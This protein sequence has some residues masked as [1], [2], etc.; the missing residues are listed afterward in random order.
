MKRISTLFSLLVLLAMLAQAQVAVVYDPEGNITHKFTSSEVSKIVWVDAIHPENVSLDV[1]EKQVLHRSTFSLTATVTPALAEDKSLSWST[2]DA[3]VATVTDAGLVTCVGVGSATITV[4]TVDGHKTAT[5]SVTVN[6][7]L[8]TGVRLNKTKMLLHISNSE[9]L[10]ATITPE[11]ASDKSVTWSSDNPSVATVDANGRVSAVAE[12]LASIMVATADEKFVDYCI[13]T[14]SQHDYVDL[15]LSVMWAPYNIGATCPEEYGDCYAWGETATKS[16][17]SWSNY[18]WC[19]GTSS[20]MTKYCTNSGDGTVDEKNVLEPEDDIAT[21]LWG[22]SWRMPSLA[23]LDE[24]YTRCTW[25]WTDNYNSTGVAGYIVKSNVTGY[26]D[27]TIFLPAAG[28]YDT[29]RYD[30]GIYGGYWSGSLTDGQS[31]C[32]DYMLFSSDKVAT[33][34]IYRY[35]GLSARPVYDDRIYVTGIELGETELAW[36]VGDAE[37]LDVTISPA[38]AT[39]K[40]VTWT[41]SKP[42]VLSVDD[43][44][45]ITALAVGSATITATTV[46][47]GYEASCTIT[48][49]PYHEYV[50]LGLSVKWATFN[51]GATSQDMYGDY[52]AWG[53]TDERDNYSYE[54]YSWFNGSTYDINKYCTNENR[55]TVDG[56]TTLEPDDDVAHVLWGGQWRMPTEAE[57]KELY[58]NCDRWPYKDYNGTGVAGHLFTSRKEGYTAKSVFLPAGSVKVDAKDVELDGWGFYWSS[59]LSQVSSDQAGC[60]VLYNNYD[61]SLMS[62]MRSDGCTIRPVRP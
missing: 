8:V 14:V 21:V 50:D 58:E 36:S 30:N 7:V 19:N 4:A 25:T 40:E 35:W 59:T 39:R 49:S 27:G 20:S 28:Y 6:P 23:E 52:Y 43:S 57:F 47:G 10:T 17:Y 41:S 18:T 62:R 15:G 29:S 9:T 51:V 37:K 46:D 44:G 42:D 24:L 56:K 22:G 5:C 61:V 1:T 55:G 33:G 13:V 3:S 12:G 34:S 31:D 2:S 45:L 32:A 48:V 16:T 53:E 54:T 11:N 26:T 60:F 38:Y